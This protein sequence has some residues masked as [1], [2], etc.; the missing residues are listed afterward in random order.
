[1]I[2]DKYAHSCRLIETLTDVYDVEMRDIPL[3]VLVVPARVDVLVDEIPALKL[4]AVNG[5]FTGVIAT[6]LEVAIIT[7]YFV[8]PVR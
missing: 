3:A 7:L 1:M 6:V 4:K 8:M 5:T 2:S